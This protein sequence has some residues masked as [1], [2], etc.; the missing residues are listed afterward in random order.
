MSAYFYSYSVFNSVAVIAILYSMTFSKISFADE[1]NTTIKKALPLQQKSFN[2]DKN[3]VS[4]APS[5]SESTSTQELIGNQQ[6]LVITLYPQHERVNLID[7]KGLINF[8]PN[9]FG[10]LSA[11]LDETTI[12]T[13]LKQFLS[14]KRTQD[15]FVN[16]KALEELQLSLS[17]HLL[18]LEHGQ[19]LKSD[20]IA[21]KEKLLSLLTRLELQSTHLAKDREWREQEQLLKNRLSPLND[22]WHADESLKNALE[23]LI[24][25]L[26]LQLNQKNI[27]EKNL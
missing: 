17:N 13:V 11:Y 1:G 6:S 2:K 3:K 4:T 23:P 25:Q 12:S 26:N 24:T 16:L 15:L 7:S 5:N 19:A 10:R 27:K 21:Y 20:E 8:W 14:W 9:F 18:I 22:L